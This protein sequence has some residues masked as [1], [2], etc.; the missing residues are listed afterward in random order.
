MKKDKHWS[1]RNEIAAIAAELIVFLFVCA[2]LLIGTF[3][4]IP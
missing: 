2:V 3:N 4:L 1:R